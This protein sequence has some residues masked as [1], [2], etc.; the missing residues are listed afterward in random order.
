M[1]SSIKIGVAAVG[2][3]ALLAS[4]GA[5]QGSPVQVLSPAD[6]TTLTAHEHLN[7]HAQKPMAM[8][9]IFQVSSDLRYTP[10]SWDGPREGDRCTGFGVHVKAVRGGMFGNGTG[11]VH[12]LVTSTPGHYAG[13]MA[14]FPGAPSIYDDPH[15]PEDMQPY[16]SLG[17]GEYEWTVSWA[18]WWYHTPSWGGGEWRCGNQWGGGQDKEFETAPRRFT[19]VDAVAPV[20]PPAP[21]PGPAAALPP[22]PAAAGPANPFIT[23]NIK[24]GRLAI[25]QFGKGKT[26]VTV[27]CTGKCQDT[28]RYEVKVTGPKTKVKKRNAK[29][30]TVRATYYRRGVIKQGKKA[31]NITFTLPKKFRGKKATIRLTAWDASAKTKTVKAN[32]KLE[33]KPK[34]VARTTKVKVKA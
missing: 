31:Q 16:G 29:A 12:P 9:P 20:A 19:V 24:R 6:G 33:V 1:K 27:K 17:A 2:A 8:S 30:K 7:A 28:F 11:Y 10:N 25:K 15:R 22:A 14:P 18:T 3:T 4:A 26:R 23:P 21:A 5:A 13:Y 34:Q 32:A